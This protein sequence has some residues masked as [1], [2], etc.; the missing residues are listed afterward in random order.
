MKV[1][2]LCGRMLDASHTSPRQRA[3]HGKEQARPRDAAGHLVPDLAGCRRVE[4]P[5]AVHQQRRQHVHRQIPAE[6]HHVDTVTGRKMRRPYEVG[7]DIAAATTLDEPVYNDVR[8]VN[9]NTSSYMHTATDSVTAY[10]CI[11]KGLEVGKST[12]AYTGRARR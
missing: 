5:A 4:E 7:S 10:R 1:S 11:H 8:L 12:D 9:V 6:A 2:L 3:V